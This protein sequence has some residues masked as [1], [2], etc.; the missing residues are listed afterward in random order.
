MSEEKLNDNVAALSDE[1]IKDIMLN[2]AEIV[3]E[4]SLAAVTCM[5]AAAAFSDC[6]SCMAAACAAIA[7]GA[8]AAAIV[9]DANAG[10]DSASTAE[11]FANAIAESG[12]DVSSKVLHVVCDI[13]RA[14]VPGYG[15][16]RDA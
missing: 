3:S 8:D 9:A 12:G 10:S 2:T 13:K 4:A 5:A 6:A 7:G 15:E 11:S 14:F 16:F 1:E